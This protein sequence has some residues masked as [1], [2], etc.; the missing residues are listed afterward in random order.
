MGEDWAVRKFSV[1][2]KSKEMIKKK[3][4]WL[5]PVELTS[6]KTLITRDSDFYAFII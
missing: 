5:H 3:N 1:Q 2:Y 4:A 6:T